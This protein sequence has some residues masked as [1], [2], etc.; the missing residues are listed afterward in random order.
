[1]ILP[2]KKYRTSIK[3]VSKET[4]RDGG[5]VRKSNSICWRTMWDA[6]LQFFCEI[7]FT[8]ENIG[9]TL[10]I[11]IQQILPP[12]LLLLNSS[13]WND[14]YI[15]TN[16]ND[17]EITRLLAST[18]NTWAK[19]FITITYCIALGVNSDT[20]HMSLRHRAPSSFNAVYMSHKFLAPV[21]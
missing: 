10:Y 1:M 15:C 5:R 19:L 11:V 7:V 4:S 21:L 17:T 12:P 3:I 18:Y 9:C 2:K 20:L 6:S 13:F 8:E 16:L 14:F